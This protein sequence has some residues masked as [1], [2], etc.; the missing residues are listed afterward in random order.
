MSDRV[1]LTA[2]WELFPLGC[3]AMG[4]ALGIVHAHMDCESKAS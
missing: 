3:R 1:T 4:W 2:D